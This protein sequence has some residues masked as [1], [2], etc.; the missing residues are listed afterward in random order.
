MTKNERI[1]S[2][3]S[4]ALIVG[5]AGAAVVLATLSQGASARP[6]LNGAAVSI[7]KSASTDHVPVG[8]HLVYTLT[9]HN[10]STDTAAHGVIITDFLD[11]NV[12]YVT[13]WPTPDGGTTHNTPYWNV[14]V[15]S[16][17][18][19]GTIVLTVSVT[20]PLANGTILTNTAAVD[21]NETPS[22]T[23]QVTT[24]VDAPVLKLTQR[25]YPDPVA[26]GAALTYT[27]T[28]SNVGD[29]DAIGVVI[30]DA[31]DSNVIYVSASPPASGTGAVR[32][33]SIGILTA[34]PPASGMIVVHVTVQ[35]GLS[36]GTTLTNVATID[37]QYTQPL[38][39]TE[40]TVVSHGAPISVALTPAT[41]A[42]SAGQF[43]SYTLTAYDA[44]GN[45]WDVTAGGA[46]TITP[47]AG[48]AWAANVYTAEKDATW[49]ITAT[50]QASLTDTAALTVTNVAPTAVISAPTTG[51]EGETLTFDASLSHD[52]GNDIV[53]HEWGFGDGVTATGVLVSHAYTD[54]ASYTITL[55]VTD[56]YNASDTAT[57]TVIIYN[58]A[59]T[60]TFNAPTEVD[61]GDDIALS[62]T[63]PSDPSSADTAAG[64]DYA[65]DCGSGYG[66]WG[67]TSTA[68]CPTTD[69]GP[70]A[71]GGKIRDKDGA[72]TE[73]TATVT[74]NNVAPTATFN[75]PDEVDEG[76]EGLRSYI[77]EI[78]NNSRQMFS[79]VNNL[80]KFSVKDANETE[81]ADIRHTVEDALGVVML[82]AK[83]RIKFETNMPEEP[84][85]LEAKPRQL[86]QVW[87]NLL[88]NACDAV[89]ERQDREPSFFYPGHYQLECRSIQTYNQRLPFH[90]FTLM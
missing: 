42:I 45:D 8:T 71:V 33:W 46:Y 19:T 4:I 55:T 82:R 65:F 9:Y 28:Y 77:D 10:T 26:A 34:T 74:V 79:I 25:D 48:G 12:L 22:Q 30:T 72:E 83:G 2:Q 69:D 57:Q 62:L 90:W 76:V 6:L 7:S 27:L 14:G 37:G 53:S 31:L 63:N 70:V 40:T 61:E 23:A 16:E 86:V 21:S 39:V 73:Y 1:F 3:F 20:A 13:A 5:I 11:A 38:S 43:I 18:A 81:P 17:S 47:A 68:S 56:E 80:R 59:P 36:E 35:S 49:T 85:I 75:A 78:Y 50:Y 84:V 15:L 64:F 87:T 24:T 29:A 54:N 41:A 67:A 88:V 32:Y 52:P 58:V 51:D 44:Y 66:D 89:F 60:A